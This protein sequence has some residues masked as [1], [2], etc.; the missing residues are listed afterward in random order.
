MEI[1]R[2]THRVETNVDRRGIFHMSA[3][4]RFLRVT[5][6]L[7]GRAPRLPGTMGRHHGHRVPVRVPGD[8]KPGVLFVAPRQTEN[9]HRRV[10]RRHGHVARRHHSIHENVQRRRKPTVRDVVGRLVHRL[11][12]FR[13]A[14]DAPIAVDSLRRTVPDG[15]QRYVVSV[16]TRF[17]SCVTQQLLTI[18]R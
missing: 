5:V 13:P 18:C 11:R 7:G 14:G 2:G 1:V 3:R 10:Q 17:F 15:R 6:L 12:V 8:R 16:Y 4:L 9:A